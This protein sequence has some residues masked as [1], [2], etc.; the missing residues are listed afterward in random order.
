MNREEKEDLIVD[1]LREMYNHG[2]PPYLLTRLQ[3]R[4]LRISRHI[5]YDSFLTICSRLADS[6]RIIFDQS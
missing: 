2:T 1:V 3:E 5:R 6:G 4:V